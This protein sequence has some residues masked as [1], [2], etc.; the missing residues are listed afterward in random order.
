VKQSTHEVRS[1]TVSKKSAHTC[2]TGK[3]SNILIKRKTSDDNA[4]AEL[5]LASPLKNIPL[6]N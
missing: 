3:N 5:L 2:V 6:H 4:P 1:L